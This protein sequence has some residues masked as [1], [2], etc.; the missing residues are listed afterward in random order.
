MTTQA[1]AEEIA[2]RLPALLVAAER[3]A[4]TVAAGMHGRRRTGPGETF[5][6]YRP[7]RAGDTAAA[8]DWRQSARG[9]RLFVRETEWSAA[10]TVWLWVDRSASMNW[11][12]GR[13]V[14][15]KGERARV[16]ALALATL[17]FKGGERVAALAN[18]A[19]VV[20]APGAL[21]RLAGLLEEGAPEPAGVPRHG[22]VV[23]L[24]DFLM[25]LAETEA[26]V[27]RLAATGA[28]GHLLQ[29]LDPAEEVLPFAG[30]IRFAGLEGEGETLV[31]RTEGVRDGYRRRLAGHLDGLREIAAAA[32]WSFARHH[33]DHPPQTALLA[34][35]ALLS[36]EG[37][38]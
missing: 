6:Q 16:L 21:A 18:G 1:Q 13:E 37:G 12:S 7:H 25:P 17:L 4:A 11:R 36:R 8:I 2:S 9:D 23:L 20:A 19:A 5:W 32:G 31:R 34:L 35:H 29:V 26:M 15:F 14:P 22:E 33:T 3:V 30:R 38:R 28:R 27:R 24:S 10:Q